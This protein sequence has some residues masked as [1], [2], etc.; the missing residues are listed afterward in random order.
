M[1]SAS[2]G[3]GSFSRT[4]VIGRIVVDELRELVVSYGKTGYIALYR[5]RPAQDQAHI[6]AI[7]HQCELD[8]PV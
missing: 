3:T 7:R 8:Y 5:F 2:G 6:L 4:L 1:M